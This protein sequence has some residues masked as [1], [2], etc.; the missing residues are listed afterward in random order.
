MRK[1]VF[2]PEAQF[3]ELDLLL[4]DNMCHVYNDCTL[5]SCCTPSKARLGFEKDMN[6]R[7]YVYIDKGIRAEASDNL[8]FKEF[9]TNGKLRFICMEDMMEFLHSLQPLFV[10]ASANNK[11]PVRNKV[12]ASSKP[13]APAFNPEEVKNYMDEQAKNKKMVWPEQIAE[14]LKIKVFGQD[15]VIDDISRKI[16]INQ[17]RQNP[18][19]LVMTLIG[20]TATGKSETAKSLSAVL[21]ELYDCN[22][23]YIEIAGSEFIGEHQVHRFFG[24]PPGYIG[25]GSETVLEPVRRNPRHVIVINE[26]EKADVKIL[27]GLMEAFDNG[28][29]GMADNSESIDLNQCIMFLTSNLPI[30][31]KAYTGCKSKFVRS[32]LCRDAFTKHCGRP[33]ISGKIGNFLAFNPLSIEATMKIAEKF[34]REELDNYSLSLAQ[35]E[36]SL[37][38]DLIKHQT[39]YGARGIRELVSD[40]IGD[41]L[42]SERRLEN[43]KGSKVSLAGTIDNIAINVV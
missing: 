24:A 39:K 4:N 12:S 30:D 42:L 37:M 36:N 40:C 25:Y 5:P 19:L 34:I 6:N 23:G 16:V 22:Y 10:N 35:I 43:I 33:E 20:P 15:D 29:V 3:E 17:M 38:S 7:Y 11:V 27:T 2:A 18:K 8:D 32:E 14:K 9:L 21:S 13:Q 31:M 28:F 41:Y 26:I 1:F